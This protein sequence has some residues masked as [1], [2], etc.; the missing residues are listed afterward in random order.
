MFVK[1]IPDPQA[2]IAGF[3][4]GDVCSQR[5]EKQ[6]RVL[7]Q[8]FERFLFPGCAIQC[9]F[10]FEVGPYIPKRKDPVIETNNG[11]RFHG[12]KWQNISR[13]I[14]PGDQII[15]RKIRAV[16]SGQAAKNFESDFHFQ[17]K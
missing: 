2:Q 17:I 16:W 1:R 13:N 3:I 10:F 9:H 5:F 4:E 15:F 7:P 14:K 6:L 8:R 12:Q 11:A